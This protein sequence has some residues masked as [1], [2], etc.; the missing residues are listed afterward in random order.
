MIWSDGFSFSDYINARLL[1]I[2]L[3]SFS[4]VVFWMFGAIPTPAFGSAC[5]CCTRW[6]MET[7]PI[8][9]GVVMETQ[10]D[11]CFLNPDSGKSWEESEVQ[12]GETDYLVR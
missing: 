12:F 3:C 7:Q 10:M 8:I 11:A 1:L 5:R 9:S 2:D 6:I 4:P